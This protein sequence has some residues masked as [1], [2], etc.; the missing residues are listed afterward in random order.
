MTSKE[1]VLSLYCLKE[2]G[3]KGFGPQKIFSFCDTNY[4][5]AP[6]FTMKELQEKIKEQSS[7]KISLENLSSS[8]DLACQYIEES[9]KRD[10]FLS[11]Y[12][13]DSYP[14]EFKKTLDESGRPS[15]PLMIWYKGDL[16]IT[17]M[18][19]I[20]IIGTR[21]PTEDGA[22]GGELVSSSLASCGFNIISGLA[23]GCDTCAHKGALKVNG[24]TTAIL[25][26]GLDWESIYPSENLELSKDIYEMGG[27]LISEYPIGYKVNKYSLVARDRLQAGMAKGTIVIQTGA[28][29]GT[30]HAANTTLISKK[31]LY[32]LLFKSQMTNISEFCQGNAILVKKGAKYLSGRD[33]LD[34]F[35]A[36]RQELLGSL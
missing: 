7:F 22:I 18:P 1:L 36:V 5:N 25:A 19:G 6:Y 9:A 34:S 4:Y 35:Y 29:G 16:D 3:Y 20:A 33:A 17:K 24:K 15:P 10:I 13:D 14:S 2:T 12:W 21:N 11:C 26:N 27:L 28:K 30:M 32:A 31:P 8:Y 23:I